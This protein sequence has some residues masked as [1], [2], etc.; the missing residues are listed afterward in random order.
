MYREKNKYEEAIQE[1]QV[2]SM[3][4]Q[5]ELQLHIDGETDLLTC[6]QSLRRVN[7]ENE[8]LK[9]SL[10]ELTEV[11]EPVAELFELRGQGVEPR[12]LTD[13]LWDTAG[14]LLADV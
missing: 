1:L 13:C 9:K 4:L 5:R 12:L 7:D 2:L 3:E 14:A 10:K 6:M 8:A 11:A